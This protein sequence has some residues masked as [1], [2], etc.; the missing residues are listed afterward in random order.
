MW[1]AEVKRFYGGM[2]IVCGRRATQAHHAYGKAAHPDL[3]HES[4]N[5]VPLCGKCHTRAHATPELL[6][7]LQVVAQEQRRALLFGR[8][9]PTVGEIGGIIREHGGGGGGA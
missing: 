3:R 7:A 9:W 5:G 1:R 4:F 8:E 6:T 2:C